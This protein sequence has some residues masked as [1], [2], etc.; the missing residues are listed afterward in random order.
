MYLAEFQSGLKHAPR[1]KKAA[2]QAVEDR[3]LAT[4]AYNGTITHAAI[5]NLNYAAN[6]DIP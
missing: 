2:R 6:S 4:I 5:F 1:L 3:P